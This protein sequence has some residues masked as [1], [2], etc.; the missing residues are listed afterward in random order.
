MQQITVLILAGGQGRRLDGSDKG[1]LSIAGRPLIA[2]ILERLA[3]CGAQIMI[4]ANRNLERYAD[5]GVPVHTDEIPGFQGP[6]AGICSVLPRVN[7]PYVLSLPCD[8]PLFPLDLGQRLLQNLA[9]HHARLAVAHDGQR[10]QPLCSLMSTS[11]GESLSLYLASGKR[12]VAAWITQQPHI[13]VDFSDQ[14]RA[15]LNI[16]SN[17]ELA[18]FREHP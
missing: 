4:S 3:G 15:F 11:L 8:M 14:P 12:Q 5:F 6:L 10:L 7:T 18:A 9:R 16:N 13:V 2:R 1:L 17:S